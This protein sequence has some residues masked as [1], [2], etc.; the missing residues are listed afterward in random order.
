[1]RE[2]GPSR[3]HDPCILRSAH[4]SHTRCSPQVYPFTK[5]LASASPYLASSILA[6]CLPAWMICAEHL[7]GRLRPFADPGGN[8]VWPWSQQCS[9]THWKPLVLAMQQGSSSIPWRR[10]VLLVYDIVPVPGRIRVW[11][12]LLGHGDRII[13]LLVDTKCLPLSQLKGSQV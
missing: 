9:C 2:S 8:L 13:V 10:L 1:M 4:L 3:M 6:S 7:L 11:S 5:T 12:V